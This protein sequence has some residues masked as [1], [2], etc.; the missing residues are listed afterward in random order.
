MTPYFK[1]TPLYSNYLKV[2]FWSIPYL[3]KIDCDFKDRNNKKARISNTKM[4]HCAYMLHF[5][6]ETSFKKHQKPR[7]IDKKTLFSDCR[8]Q[9]M[10]SQF[11][12]T[13]YP[14]KIEIKFSLILFC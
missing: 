8:H 11:Q 1:L 5:I 4:S 13:L 12:E 6:M 3:I 7:N 14:V 9:A 10:V 2:S